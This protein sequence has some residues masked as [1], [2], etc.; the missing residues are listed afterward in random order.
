MQVY[1]LRSAMHAA[2]FRERIAK[3]AWEN[4]SLAAYC[5]AQDRQRRGIRRNSSALQA[6]PEHC[7]CL[8]CNVRVCQRSRQLTAGRVGS[9]RASDPQ[10]TENVHQTK[11]PYQK[12]PNVLHSN[13]TPIPLQ[14]HPKKPTSI[15]HTPLNSGISCF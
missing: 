5:G 13:T 14:Y 4:W 3:H 2:R 6:A 7:R 12:I 15:P 1:S 11:T 10:H 8:V 9:L